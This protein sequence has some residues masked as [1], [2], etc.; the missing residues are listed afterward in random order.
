[1]P[2]TVPRYYMFCMTFNRVS[3]TNVLH[4]FFCKGVK[5]DLE[6][7]CVRDKNPKLKR[8]AEELVVGLE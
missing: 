4:V 7:T 1:M 8:L 3:G 6:K 5:V 2:R